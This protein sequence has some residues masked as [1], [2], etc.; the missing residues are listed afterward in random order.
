MA[1]VLKY[2]SVIGLGELASDLTDFAKR[3]RAL[4]SLLAEPKRT[5]FVAVTR[6]ATLPRLET[7]RLVRQ[8][9]RLRVP[10]AAVVANA[11]TATPSRC[12][13]CDAAADLERVEL[14]RLASLAGGA[15]VLAPAT[16]PG[17][18]GIE[19]LARWRAKWQCYAAPS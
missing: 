6:P 13:R 10:L 4:I 8:L 3:L 17:P 19:A 5:A 16:Y 7:E 1:T 18:R 12:T 11:V 15:L 9:G 2:R 14:T